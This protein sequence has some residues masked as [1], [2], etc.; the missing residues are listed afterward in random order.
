MLRRLAALPG[1]LQRALRL[2]Y[3][4]L[5]VVSDGASFRT[6]RRLSRAQVHHGLAEGTERLRL[7]PLEG[8]PVEVRPDTSDVETVWGVFARRYH[9]P[10]RELGEPAVI[11]DLG[12]NIG[13]TTAHFAVLYANARILGVELD[14]RNVELARRNTAAWHDR[15]E[16]LHA[17]VW[18]TDGEVRYERIAG[19]TAT[20]KVTGG[21]GR[22]AAP[23][24]S[25]DTLLRD[26]GGPV[27]YL[28][29]DVEGAERALLRERTDWA[30]SVGCVNVEVHGDY[31][32]DEC[33]HDLR[34]LG[35]EARVEDPRQASVVGLR[36][37]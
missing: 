15:C 14:S 21:G 37:G 19:G 6:Y 4:R 10:P 31:G 23:A 27:D 35:F 2:A 32:V 9:L 20:Y 24:V 3:V 36:P 11:W 7:R 1:P 33:A 8:R 22:E 29:I 12:A 16:V 28:K 13:L 26:H 5:R 30:A 25:L 18:P 17:A 34:I